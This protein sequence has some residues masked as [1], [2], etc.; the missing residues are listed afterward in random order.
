MYTIDFFFNSIVK[1]NLQ[2]RELYAFKNND[3]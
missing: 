2:S 3:L 1:L